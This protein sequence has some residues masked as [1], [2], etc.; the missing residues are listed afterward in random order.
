[1]LTLGLKFPGRTCCTQSSALKLHYSQLHPSVKVRHS[2]ILIF[3]DGRPADII[4]TSWTVPATV[5]WRSPWTWGWTTRSSSFWPPSLSS[6]SPS[7]LALEGS[8]NCDIVLTENYCSPA[9]SHEERVHLHPHT[10]VNFEELSSDSQTSLG[11]NVPS[12]KRHRVL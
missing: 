12:R 10:E 8:S 5:L 1:M 6:S 9:V 3:W 2:W 4:W 7:P 11:E